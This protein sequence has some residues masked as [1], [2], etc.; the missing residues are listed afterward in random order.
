MMCDNLVNHPPK[1]YFSV[2]LCTFL[3][4][5][6]V[7]SATPT[8]AYMAFVDVPKPKQ[9]QETL[10]TP[11]VISNVAALPTPQVIR[12]SIWTPPYLSETLG[13]TLP[14]PLRALSV[15]DSATANVNLEVGEQN[16]VSQW[17]YALV[18]PFSSTMQGLSSEDLIASWQG[19]SIDGFGGQPLLMD[20]N[21]VEMFSVLWGPAADTRVQ[22]L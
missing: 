10:T 4:S 5:S 16:L 15:A 22:I 12:V 17:V 2:M 14:D 7:S 19:G 11:S 8:P 20:Q 3:F 21:T 13:E 9:Q 6:C 18:T 1:I